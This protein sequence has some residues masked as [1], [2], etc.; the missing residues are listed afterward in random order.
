MKT[1]RIELLKKMLSDFVSDEAGQSTTEY[2]L[3]LSAVVMIAIKFK[4]TFA[5]KIEALVGK[6]GGQID[7]A[8]TEQ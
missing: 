7:S 4:S 3:M 8:T 1:T 2:I 6:L 5:G